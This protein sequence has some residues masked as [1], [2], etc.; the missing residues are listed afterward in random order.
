MIDKSTGQVQPHKLIALA[1]ART[2]H[3]QSI[4]LDRQKAPP[5]RWQL[6][7]MVSNTYGMTD[8]PLT[9]ATCQEISSMPDF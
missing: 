7:P 6:V 8:G 9:I 3:R 1:D 2:A 5:A 4:V